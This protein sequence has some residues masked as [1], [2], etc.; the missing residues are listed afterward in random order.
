MRKCCVSDKPPTQSLTRS[1]IC[2]QKKNE[3][4]ETKGEQS[5]Q[6]ADTNITNPDNF[7]YPYFNK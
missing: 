1:K 6:A 2:M 7:I 5:N 4:V 3:Q